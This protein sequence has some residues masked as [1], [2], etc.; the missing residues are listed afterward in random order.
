MKYQ[1]EKAIATRSQ[2]LRAALKVFARKGY[3]A[4]TLDDV[5]KE[6]DLSRGAIYFSFKNKQDLYVTLVREYFETTIHGALLARV[7]KE[8]DPLA[9]LR[10]YMFSY[11]HAVIANEEI[12]EFMEL[13]RYKTEVKTLSEEILA[14]Q[15]KMDLL[16]QEEIALLVRA[17]LKSGV[18][19]QDVPETLLTMAI[20]SY[21][22]GIESTWLFNPG[23]FPLEVHLRDLIDIFVDSMLLQR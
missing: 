18:L 6:A 9:A 23:I 10:D 19:R 8:Q 16:M 11:N 12:R 20:H 7:E 21:L 5:A 1:Q 13:I 2:V 14:V 3:S 4:T 17:C 15:Q 22:N